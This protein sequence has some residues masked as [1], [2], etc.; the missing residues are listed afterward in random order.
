MTC[1]VQVYWGNFMTGLEGDVAKIGKS[2]FFS[3]SWRNYFEVNLSKFSKSSG[4]E[5]IF[6]K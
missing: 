5:Q 6:M 2:M 3:D 4:S 1:N